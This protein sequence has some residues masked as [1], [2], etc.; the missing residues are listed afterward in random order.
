MLEDDQSEHRLEIWEPVFN[1]YEKEYDPET[2]EWSP[3]YLKR[4]GVYNTD[5]AVTQYE[6]TCGEFFEDDQ[7]AA[8]NHI[9][10]ILEGEHE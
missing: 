9:K 4:E 2:E 5:L 7:E 6:C 1:K 10:E 8:E 3:S